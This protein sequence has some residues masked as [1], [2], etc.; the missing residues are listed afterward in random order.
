MEFIFAKCN[1]ALIENNHIS[2]HRDGIYFEFVTESSIL[3]NLQLQKTYDMDCILCFHIKII[4]QTI[5]L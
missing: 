5:H 3:H 2:G 4:V 1:H